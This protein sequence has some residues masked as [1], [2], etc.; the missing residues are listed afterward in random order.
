MERGFLSQKRS[1]GGRGVKE[2]NGVVKDG[3]IPSVMVTSGNN[4]GTQEANLVK[5]VIIIC[6]MRMLG[7]HQVTLLLTWTKSILELLVNGLLTAYG[8]FLGKQLAYPVVANY[9]K[10]TWGKYGLDLEVNLMKEDVVNLPVEVKLHGVPMTEC[11]EERLSVI[12]T[13]LGTS[14]MLDSYTFEMCV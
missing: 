13:K 1:G 8:F 2:K 5:V 3:G 4:F 6:M 7:R 9:V 12:P 14:L 11:S 10:N